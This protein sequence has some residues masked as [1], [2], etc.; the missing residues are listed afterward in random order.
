MAL[1]R[2]VIGPDVALM[3]DANGGYETKQAQRVCREAADLDVVWF[4]EPVSSDRLADLALLRATIEP[5]VTAGEYG[6]TTEYFRR[7]CEAGAVD[8]LQVDATRCGGYSGMLA[9]AAVADSHGLSV[10]AHCG[11]HLHAPVCAALP[12]LRHVEWFADHVYADRML[13]DGLPALVAG[14]MR[15][16]EGGVPGHG[17]TLRADGE[18]LRTA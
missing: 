16:G 17:V 14:K 3:V 18:V 11:P 13:F 6:T 5:E 8:C 1:A 12:N 10:S 4:E 2:E 15:P 7:M 9:A